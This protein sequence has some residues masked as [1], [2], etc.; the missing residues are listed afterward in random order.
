[1]S[2]EALG[3][4]HLNPLPWSSLLNSDCS[5][6]QP[7]VIFIIK[8]N[9]VW[10]NMN[11]NI[12]RSQDQILHDHTVDNPVAI[13]QAGLECNLEQN[14]GLSGGWHLTM[15]LINLEKLLVTSAR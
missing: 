11:S 2:Y 1:M 10:N 5:L 7:D 9:I 4:S 15:K 8:L 3:W 6:A 12:I 14:L 13:L